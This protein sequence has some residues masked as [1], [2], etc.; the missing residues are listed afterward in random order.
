M[1]WLA[2]LRLAIDLG[3]FRLNSV[4]TAGD[5]VWLAAGL[6]VLV[7]LTAFVIW[8]SQRS[9]PDPFDLPPGG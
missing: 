8:H 6:L 2:S 5:I 4:T 3:D 1:M 9:Q 7:G